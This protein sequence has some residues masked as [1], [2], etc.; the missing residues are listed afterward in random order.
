MAGSGNANDSVGDVPV[1]TLIEGVMGQV[2]DLSASVQV[3]SA[4][5]AETAHSSNH[6]YHRITSL[7][8]AFDIPSLLGPSTMAHNRHSSMRWESCQ[9]LAH[10]SGCRA[11]WQRNTT[12]VNSMRDEVEAKMVARI[13][14]L[15]HQMAEINARMDLVS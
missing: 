1:M 5:T 4:G 6:A 3:A 8:L 2:A 15:H 9:L 11:L 12:L 13:E 14:P 7:S 10:P